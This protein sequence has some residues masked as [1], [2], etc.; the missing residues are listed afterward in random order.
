MSSMLL[1]SE[2]DK[3]LDLAY[4]DLT[5]NLFNN[6]AIDF[7]SDKRIK[8]HQLYWLAN[9]Y[10]WGFKR[11]GKYVEDSKKAIDL[12]EKA[13][14]AGSGKACGIAGQLQWFNPDNLDGNHLVKLFSKGCDLEDADSCSSL[15]SVYLQGFLYGIDTQGRKAIKFFKKACELGS[16]VGCTNLKIHQ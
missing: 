8:A 9:F 6:R 1:A 11:N 15:G 4:D 16:D 7:S 12:Y 14:F 2:Y 13:C 3:K 5:T 10:S